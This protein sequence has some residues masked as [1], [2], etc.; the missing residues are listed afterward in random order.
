MP[1]TNPDAVK[2][3]EDQIRHALIL[4]HPGL[5]L[6]LSSLFQTMRTLQKF[7]ANAIDL[8]KQKAAEYEDKAYKCHENGNAE[9]RQQFKH[10]HYENRDA[11]F[12]RLDA[13]RAIEKGLEQL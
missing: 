11:Y 2:E 10:M 7:R 4:S 8:C 6:K 13:V 9:Q 12:A 1:D 5:T 3:L